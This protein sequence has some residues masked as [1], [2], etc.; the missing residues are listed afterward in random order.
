MVSVA[1]PVMPDEEAEIVIV[2]VFLPVATPL[3]RIEAIFGFDDFQV[4]P[5]RFEAT[6]PS[7]N[8]PLTVNLMDVRFDMRGLAGEIVIETSCTF[9]TVRLV[10]PLTEPSAALIVV[11][12]VAPLLARPWALMVA[13][14]GF[15]DDQIT[16]AVMS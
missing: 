2:P 10:D 9:E 16:E 15:E 13:A 1:V 3:D 8:V 14:A 5:L 7:L 4:I 6:L 11:L 12:P